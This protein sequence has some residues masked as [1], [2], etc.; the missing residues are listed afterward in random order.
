[1]DERE[2]LIE[3]LG[4][5]STERINPRTVEIDR[6]GARE[7]VRL[8]NEEDTGVAAVVAGAG[9]KIA[10][11]AQQFADTLKNNGRV[12]YIGAGTSGRLGVLDAAE[13]PPTFG[14]DPEQIVGVISGGYAT[15]VLSKEGVED[16]RTAAVKDLTDRGI[17]TG[18]LV[19]GLAASA[20]TPYTL[21]G[22]EYAHQTG[23]RTAF[24]VCNN[25]DK[26]P[27][28]VDT[29]IELTVGPE[30]ITGSTRMKSGTAQKM[31]LN[32]ISTTAMVLMGKTYGNLM[33]DLQARSEKLAARSRKM[34]MELLDLSL[35]ESD[36]LLEKAGGSVKIAIVMHR[37][38]CSAEIA[39]EKLAH[40][41]GFVRDC[42]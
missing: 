34:L 30:V 18:D 25:L 39:A 23:C 37:L 11:V 16:D 13:C 14:T 40:A 20:R 28:F 32:A 6:L 22:L 26:S 1:M 35:S 27:A 12:F 42:R 41:G 21:A 9:D 29:V 33:V 10:I 15:L 4:K 24:V 17:R 7:I 2:Q 8:I 5:L 38:N 19:I 36:C 3:E 31:T